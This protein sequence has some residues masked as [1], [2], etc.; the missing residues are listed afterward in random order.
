MGSVKIRDLVAPISAPSSVYIVDATLAR[1][2]VRV[3]PYQRQGREL[4][5]FSKRVKGQ[6]VWLDGKTQWIKIGTP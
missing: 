2:V 1:G 5:L 4:L 3:L 6:T